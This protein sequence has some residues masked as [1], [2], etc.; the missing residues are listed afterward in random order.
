VRKA[1]SCANVASKVGLRPNCPWYDRPVHPK[2]SPGRK[3]GG[4]EK[5]GW[6][7]RCGLYRRGPRRGEVFAKKGGWWAGSPETGLEHGKKGPHAEPTTCC[8]GVCR[9]TLPVPTTPEGSQVPRAVSAPG[10][11]AK[12]S[13]TPRIHSHEPRKSRLQGRGGKA[14]Q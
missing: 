14:Q 7:G 3:H 8:G 1:R 9:F 5:S 2:L 11:G 10:P 4:G 12:T 13:K 6:G